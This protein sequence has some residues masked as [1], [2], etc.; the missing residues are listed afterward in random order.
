M[1]YI[2]AKDNTECFALTTSRVESKIP[3]P[4][5]QVLSKIPKCCPKYHEQYGVQKIWDQHVSAVLTPMLGYIAHGKS[6]AFFFSVNVNLMLI[7]HFTR[8]GLPHFSLYVAYPFQ[9]VWSF[10][11][12]WFLTSQSKD[13][14][15]I[16]TVLTAHL[17]KSNSTTFYIHHQNQSVVSR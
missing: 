14:L 12:W 15:V 6:L 11:L 5:D 8:L 13:S 4:S 17:F 9:L 7:E 2:W 16:S 10:L 3:W 1:K